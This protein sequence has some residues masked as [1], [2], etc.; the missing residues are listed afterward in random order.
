MNQLL[1]PP[2]GRTPAPVMAAM[3]SVVSIDNFLQELRRGFAREK[4][5]NAT[6]AVTR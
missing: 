1:H 3:W 6:D 2:S 4:C 5:S